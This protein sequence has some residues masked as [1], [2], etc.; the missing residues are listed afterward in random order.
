MS[1][2]KTAKLKDLPVRIIDGDRS[3][4]Y[5]KRNEFQDN[6][7]LFLN[8]TNIENNRL[9]LEQANF[10]TEEKFD[11]ITKGRLQRL[12]IVMTTR[13]S[14][15]KVALF[16]CAFTTGLINA[17]MLIL[18]TAGNEIDPRFLFYLFAGDIFQAQI[19]NF[20]SGSAQPQIPIQDLRELEI[21]YP[22]IDYQRHIATV[23]SAYDD[24]IE[25]NTRRIKIL[26]EMVQMLYREW[27]VEF[28]FPGH[29]R[30]KVKNG[31]PDG[32]EVTTLGQAVAT[33]GG[34]TPSTKQPEYWQGGDVIWY[35]PSD[36]TANKA[37]FISDSK[38]KIN[39]LGLKHSSAHMFP[40]YSVMMTSRATI[41]V[42]A[43]NTIPAC[44]NQGF[45]TCIPNERVSAYQLY[46]WIEE[47]KDKILNVASGATFK[48]ISRTEFR[49]F[50]FLVADVQTNKRFSELVTPIG[51]EIENLLAKDANLR[52]TRDLLL[53]RLVSGEVDVADLEIALE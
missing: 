12:D 42:T 40:A 37:M 33:L 19:R 16:D 29:E 24:L 20:S 14:I 26:E 52:R 6:G 49:D 7:V 5:P 17:Q 39:A 53:P 47:N 27:F 23:L 41:G 43:I 4:K 11:Q 22:P 28:R 38:T 21:T 30:V 45:I 46:F 50:S 18:R 31:V 15:G 13:G 48:E 34:S 35:T 3:G 8:T 10:V 9:N 44:T 25:N 2:W 32:W 36:L 1:V 51:E